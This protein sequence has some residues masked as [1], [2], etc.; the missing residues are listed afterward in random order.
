MTR[1]TPLTW[2]STCAAASQSSRPDE[3]FDYYAIDAADL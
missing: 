2:K 1:K 3:V